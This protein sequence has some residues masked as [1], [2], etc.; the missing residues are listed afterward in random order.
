M[1]H[2]E[3]AVSGCRMTNPRSM[4]YHAII[5]MEADGRL[6]VQLHVY[7]TRRV[8]TISHVTDNAGPTT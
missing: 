5:I 2:S 3:T 4:K 8:I 7:A 6:D 1:I